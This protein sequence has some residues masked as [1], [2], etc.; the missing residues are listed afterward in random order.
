MARRSPSP[1][2]APG[3]TMG[4]L[5]ARYGI[6]QSQARKVFT[7]GFMEEPPR[8][9]PY[10]VLPPSD[11]PRFEKALEAAGYQ[12][13]KPARGTRTTKATNTRGR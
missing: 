11:L 3:Y 1:A 7:R 2:A 5:A 8:L 12:T 9:G 6:T 13:A 4:G 10:R